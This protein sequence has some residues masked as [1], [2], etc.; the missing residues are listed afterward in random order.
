[1]LDDPVAARRYGEAGRR[2][3]ASAFTEQRMLDETVRI[4]KEELCRVGDVTF[5]ITP[6]E[7]QG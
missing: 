5:P 2:R 6:L 3:V 7:A 4:Y 1:M